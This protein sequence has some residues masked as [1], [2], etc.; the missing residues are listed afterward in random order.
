MVKTSGTA[1]GND[2][3]LFEI[4]LESRGEGLFQKA[5]SN[6]FGNAFGD[7]FENAFGNVF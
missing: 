7:A 3:N 1:D 5:F 4:H 2:M 6:F